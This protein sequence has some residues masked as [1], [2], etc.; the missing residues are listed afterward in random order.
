MVGKSEDHVRERW[1][2][3]KHG[4][5]EKVKEL[6]YF[7]AQKMFRA[8]NVNFVWYKINRS[9][10]SLKLCE[11]FNYLFF[12]AMQNLGRKCLLQTHLN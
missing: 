1:T 11:I 10:L 6:K 3:S 12:F 5:S 7:I 2:L 8:K 4:V 9:D